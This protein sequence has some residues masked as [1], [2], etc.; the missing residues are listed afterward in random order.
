MINLKKINKSEIK[1]ISQIL[2]DENVEYLKYFDPFI[3]QEQFIQ[4]FLKSS[5]DIYLKIL[6]NKTFIGF[7]TL[8]GLDDGYKNPRFGIFIMEKYSNMG[9]GD[10]AIKKTLDLCKEKYNFKKIEL[11]VNKKNHTA[12]KIY[13]DNSF[14]VINESSNDQI[15]ACYL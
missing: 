8:R 10:A 3:S 9:F 15:M 11:K 7:V 5:N 13:K 2:F 14:K 1:E 6:N 4:D 12:I